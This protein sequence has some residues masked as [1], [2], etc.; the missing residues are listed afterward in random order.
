[1]MKKIVIAPDSFKGS[2][3]A[4][5]VCEIIALSARKFFP[6]AEIIQL[7][8]ADGGEG[9]VDALLEACGGEK[10][11]VPVHDP[12][13]RD[14][15][16]FYGRL[17]DGRA[18]IEM[19]AASGLPL[20]KLDERD[21]LQASTYGTGELIRHALANGARELILGLGGSAT[22]DGGAGAAAAL[23]MHYLDGA[24]NTLLCGADL[25]RLER[26]ELRGLAQGFDEAR[27]VIASDVTNP[28]YGSN[29]AAHIF[30]PQKGASPEQVQIL[31]AGLQRLAA[32]VKT[33]AGLD[34]QD[35][36]GSGAAGGLGVPF[37]IFGQAVIRRGLDVV[38]DAV[39]F[40]HH[41]A[42]CDLVITGEGRADRQSAMGKVLSGIGLRCKAKGVTAVA[43][44]GALEDGY[45]E[46]YGQ[47]ICACF[48]T[49]RRVAPLDEVLAQAADNLGRAA[50]DLL[51]LLAAQQKP[52]T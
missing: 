13:G 36:P 1:M 24:G 46:L 39:H 25:G 40:D 18:V 6:V 51:C 41:L 12:L 9:L 44:C 37:L 45:E 49:T 3:T 16:S 34:L 23:G 19:A 48:A 21:A 14:I 38:L 47:G 27:F 7:P 11:P 5:Q 33:R 43:L 4:R 32:V 10:V 28:L 31:D 8:V 22:T 26:F 20:L 42:G 30:G 35:M 2:L 29:G 52:R 17:P 15:Q 50:D